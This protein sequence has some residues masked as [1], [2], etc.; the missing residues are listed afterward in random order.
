MPAAI[1]YDEQRRIIVMGDGEFGPVPR[2][3]WEYTVGGKN[4]I[5]SWFNYRKK[6]PGGKRTSPLDH[7]HP[8]TW[9]P[10]WTREAIDLL[11]VL[12]RLVALEPAQ[13]DVLGR[14]LASQLIPMADLS[15]AGVR[16]PTIP[17]DRK[18]HYSLSSGAATTLA[19]NQPTL[20]G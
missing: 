5:K 16:W 2:Q 15:T 4:V 11:T 7:I 14:I 13:A 10:D 3:V 8:E 19:A 17:K 18:P 9:D 20:D 1:L 6:D 12:T